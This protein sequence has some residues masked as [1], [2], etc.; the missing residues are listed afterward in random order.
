M[1]CKQ[2]ALLV[3]ISLAAF[4]SCVETN[5][6]PE[7]ADKPNV[8][9]VISDDQGYGDIAAHGNPYIK[10]PHLDKFHSESVRLTDFH[11]SPT[12][13]PS[14]AAMMTGRYTNRTGAWHTIAGWSLLREEEKTLANMFNEGGYRTGAFGKWHLGD[15]YPYRVTDRG[16]EESVV[17]GGGGVQQ[18][19]DYWGNDYFDDTYFHNGIPK[20]YQGYCTDVFFN[21]A[22]KFIEE[23]QDKPFFCY[24][25]TNAP[26]WPYNVPLKY[27]AMYEEYDDNTLAPHQKQ[28]LGMITN[29]DEN[30]GKLRKQLTELQI[31]DNTI[32]IYM[33][34]NGTAAGYAKQDRDDPNSPYLGFNANMRG[35]KNHEYDGGHRVPFFIYWKD[36]NIH[37]GKDINQLTAHIDVMPSLA[38]LCNIELPQGHRKI[39][40][41]SL[42]PLLYGEEISWEDR[43]VVTDSQREQ[44]PA[45]WRKTA[46]MQNQ[47]R[48]V[49]ETELYDIKNDPS[50]TQDIS[51]KHPDVV[52]EL[53]TAYDKWW[54]DVSVDFDQ[55]MYI[56]IG[57]EFENPSVLTTHDWHAE[58]SNQRWNQLQIRNGKYG[59]GY[60]TIDVM[61]E[62]AYEIRL[63]RY[64]LESGL[65]FSA[66]PNGYTSKEEPGMNSAVPIGKGLTF[67]SAA[68]KIFG[69]NLESMNIETDT[70]EVVFKTDLK[71]GRTKLWT[72]LEDDKGEVSGA[73]Y[74]YVYKI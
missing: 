60:W 10:T 36:G 59:N 21:E 34:D 38:A 14:R 61:E 66:E 23:S 15:N 9:L 41:E 54:K 17:H 40:G 7:K 57:T 55:E 27:E 68:I 37:G 22:M 6:N 30:F 1:I 62:G 71:S 26:H 67:K 64:P 58:S 35:T 8:I 25:S 42:K 51:A 3:L 43:V 19:P 32:L 72:Y 4:C 46:V 2:I 53:T 48:L 49:N 18:T 50:Q 12:C 47:W 29:I 28:F 13:S 63:R 24:I 45:P 73:Y 52:S 39:D 11:V 65:S 56:K 20:K 5:I 31:A 44:V 70:E 33:T 74:A 69:K 16:F